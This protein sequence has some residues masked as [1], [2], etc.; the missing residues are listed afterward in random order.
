MESKNKPN[1]AG[2]Q[3]QSKLIDSNN[4]L[5]NLKSDYFIKKFFEYMSKRKSLETIRYNKSIQKRIDIN[6]NHYKAYSEKYSSIEL[7]IIPMKNK[8]GGFI[9]IKE[10]NKKYFH[11]Y[12]NDNKEKEIENTSLN[13][14]V[15]VSKISIIIDYQIKSFS[16]LF[17]C[18]NCIES[19]HFKK[20][21][22]N[23]VTIMNDMF[24]FCSSLIE[25]NLD[26][27][28]TNNV[29]NMGD[30]FYGCSSLKE[31]N[32]DNFNTNNVTNMCHMFYGCSSLKELNINNFNTNNVTSMFRMFSG[33]S[34]LI[35]LNLNNFN[36]NNVK[37]MS[38]I[39]H[40]CS[41][42]KKI[43]LSNFVTNNVTNPQRIPH[44]PAPV[45]SP[46]ALPAKPK[47]MIATVGPITTAGMILSIHPVPANLTITAINTYTKP[48]NTLPIIIPNTPREADT[49]PANAAVIEPK[50]ANELPK[51]TGLLNLVNNK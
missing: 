4:K 18:C 33:C 29:I 8:Y 17:S 9:N 16:N 13:S 34:S 23:N 3:R 11:I 42:L 43:N 6:I 15:N 46:I 49:A 51:N 27:F 20:F 7:D 2:E 21:H 5:R 38:S 10:E 25:L 12:F 35:E 28:N 39:F 41:S 37:N 40:G 36:T 1:K 24:A 26:N 32:L 14:N 50:K 30:M 22:R 48:A 47:P 19:I 44:Q 31:L 45:K